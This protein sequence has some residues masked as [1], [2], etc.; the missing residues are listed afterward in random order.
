MGTNYT[1]LWSTGATTQSIENLPA[2]TYSV[3]VTDDNGC[4]AI[5]EL[6]ITD[7]SLLDATAE[8]QGNVTCNG[9]AD[10]SRARPPRQGSPYRTRP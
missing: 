6:D 7:P 3:T 9:G 2:G 8:V 5:D 4:Q 10:G 1:Y